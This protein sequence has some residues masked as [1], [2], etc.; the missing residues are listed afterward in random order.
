VHRSPR[1]SPFLVAGNWLAELLRVQEIN[2]FILLIPLV[3]VFSALMQIAQ[4]WVHMRPS[5]E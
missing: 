5:T 1:S 3:I 2:A 4:Q